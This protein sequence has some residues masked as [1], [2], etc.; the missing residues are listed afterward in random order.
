MRPSQATENNSESRSEEFVF[1][2]KES[3]KALDPEIEALPGT[4][5]LKSTTDRDDTFR[6]S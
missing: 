1:C 3:L 5:G 2:L 6:M 4:S